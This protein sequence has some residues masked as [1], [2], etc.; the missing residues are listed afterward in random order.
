MAQSNKVPMTVTLVKQWPAEQKQWGLSQHAM[1]STD[2]GQFDCY[3]NGPQ[4][5]T[6]AQLNQPVQVKGEW[7]QGNNQKWFLACNHGQGAQQPVPGQPA[8]AQPAT[9]PAE[10]QQPAQ[11]QQPAQSQP[12]GQ[13]EDRIIR[14]NSLNAVLSASSVQAEQIGEFLRAG[15]RWIKT[16]V[17]AVGDGAQQPTGSTG[18]LT[19][20]D[21]HS[22]QPAGGTEEVPF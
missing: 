17:W 18:H 21:V 20:P 16:G 6:D 13:K 14:G 3:N 19:S 10:A 11:P 1:I 4:W 22:A 8:T 9:G 12:A 5:F 15:E 7:K 2:K